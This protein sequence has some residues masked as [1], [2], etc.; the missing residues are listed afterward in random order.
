MESGNAGLDG[1]TGVVS[2]LA[3]SKISIVFTGWSGVTKPGESRNLCTGDIVA[4]S[5]F[6][7]VVVVVDVMI[8]VEVVLIV[9]IG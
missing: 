6:I 5:T 8:G 7:F 3:T 9:V 2:L 1:S 4:S